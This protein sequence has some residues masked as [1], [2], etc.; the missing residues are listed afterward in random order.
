LRVYKGKK[1]L[2]IIP[3]RGGSK[4]VLRKNIRVVAGKP[5]IAW[6]IEEAKKSEYID[7]LIVSSEDDEI[8]AVAKAFG[9]EVPFVRP[10]E[11]ARDETPGIAPIKHAINFYL[12]NG[13]YFDYIVCLQCTSPLRMVN[14]IDGAIELALR[15]NADSVVSVCEAEH[16]PY[17]MKKVDEKGCMSNFIDDG[18]KYTRRQDLPKVYRINGAFYMATPELILKTNDWYSKGTKAFIM[19]KLRSIDIDSELDFLVVDAVLQ[20]KGT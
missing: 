15:S 16:S 20:K 8:I 17:W 12:N 6:T 7:Q 4:G 10:M 11:L 5:L 19:D 14:D 13:V 9:C 1:I 3:A 2:A 18:I